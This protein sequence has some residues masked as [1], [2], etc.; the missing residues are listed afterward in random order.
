MGGQTMDIQGPT[1]EMEVDTTLDPIP[2]TIM[3][4]GILVQ[5]GA[6]TLGQIMAME[7]GVLCLILVTTLVPILEIIMEAG[8]LVPMEGIT[9]VQTMEMEAGTLDQIMEMEDGTQ[10]DGEI[11]ILFVINC[12]LANLFYCLKN[13]SKSWS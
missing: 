12:L 4:A 3:E 9:L 1:L 5:M 13:I 10:D 8:I 2:E 6:T 11:E 7:A